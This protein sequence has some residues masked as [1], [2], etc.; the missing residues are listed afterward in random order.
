MMGSSETLNTFGG[1]SD[2]GADRSWS[3]RGRLSSASRG[4]DDDDSS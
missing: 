3:G 1:D 4:A 2:E